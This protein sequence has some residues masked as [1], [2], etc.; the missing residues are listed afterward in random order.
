M[1]LM[2]FVLLVLV[3]VWAVAQDVPESPEALDSQ[4]TA[5]RAAGRLADAD[6]VLD[7]LVELAPS[8]ANLEKS[9]RV[10]AGL[11]Q[12]E[13]AEQLYNRALELRLDSDPQPTASIPTRHQL[14]Q[15]LVAQKKFAAATQQ[16]YFAVRLR[17]LAMGPEHP[18]VATDTA[19]LARVYQTETNWTLA[20]DSWDNVVRIQSA[21]FGAE[22]LRLAASLDNLALCLKEQQMVPRS[23][24]ALRRALAIRELNLGPMHTDVA[25]TTDELGQLLY[26]V[27][28]YAEAEPFFRRS[29]EIYLAFWGAGNPQLARNYDNLAVTEAMLQR[30]PESAAHYA[31]AL[32]IRDADSAL[33]LHHLTL[34]RVA[35]GEK[36]EAELLYRRLIALLDSPGSADPEL[37]RTVTAE[38]EALLRELPPRPLPKKGKNSVAAKQK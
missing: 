18:D 35:G 23:E 21:A 13:R 10:K 27:E 36:V 2:S 31:E 7:R 34:V 6:T 29:L 1:R 12:W 9:A 20:V 16:A 30:L 15:V 33:N 17:T 14:V 8:V 4:A 3:P 32:K 11:G 28:R 22:D 37:R 38:F 24:E 26:G 19:V 5:Y 25:H